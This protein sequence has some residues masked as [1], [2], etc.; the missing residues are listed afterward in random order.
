MYKLM[1]V[2]LEVTKIYGLICIDKPVHLFVALAIAN[3][4]QN[5]N[6]YFV[7]HQLNM[8]PLH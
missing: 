3:L 5:L 2:Q 6:E 8:P 4:N 1:L 7:K